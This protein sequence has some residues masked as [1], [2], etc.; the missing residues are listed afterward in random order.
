MR[1]KNAKE[2]IKIAKGKWKS[3]PNKPSTPRAKQIKNPY[4]NW[5]VNDALDAKKEKEQE[6]E[7]Q[8]QQVEE[9]E[10]DEEA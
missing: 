9:V 8:E 10:E 7:V 6:E 5:S 4:I 2:V 1:R 3:N